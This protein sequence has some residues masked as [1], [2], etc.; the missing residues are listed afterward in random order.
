M[1]SA[2][3]SNGEV[4]R[5][6]HGLLSAG[7]VGDLSDGELLR[8]FTS[9]RGDGSALAFAELV[10]RHGAMV[11]RVCR[12][13]VRDEHDALDAFQATFL[14]L[15]RRAGL[16]RLGETVGPWLHGVALRTARGARRAAARR[17]EVERNVAGTRTAS[18]EPSL[19][20]HESAEALH[21]EIGRLPAGFRDAVVLCGLE[22]LSQEHA[23][24]RLG[25]PLGTLQSRLARGRARLRTRLERRG[26]GPA[27][28]AVGLSNETSK[29]LLP[30]RLCDT[31]VRTALAAL[32][33]TAI[34]QAAGS[35]T[36]PATVLALAKE[37]T[38]AM[39]VTQLKTTAAALGA[40][41][42]MLVCGAALA[43]GS[44]GPPDNSQKTPSPE[45]SSVNVVQFTANVDVRTKPAPLK[46]GDALLIEVLEALPNRPISGTRKV[47]SDGTI[48]L[49]FYGDIPVAGLNRDEIK[50]KVIEHLGRFLPAEK[51]GLEV[52]DASTNKTKKVPP[53]ESD[54][55]FV[56]DEMDGPKPSPKPT[57]SPSL[58]QDRFDA[59]EKRLDAL[60]ETIRK[61]RDKPAPEHS[62]AADPVEAQDRVSDPAVRITGKVRDSTTRT[63]VTIRQVPRL[64]SFNEIRPELAKA[65]QLMEVE[66][67]AAEFAMKQLIPTIEAM[68]DD[69]SEIGN[70]RKALLQKQSD[71]FNV[72]RLQ[73]NSSRESLINY[74]KERI[75]YNKRF[76]LKPGDLPAV[77]ES[78]PS[79]SATKA[80]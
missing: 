29:L 50:I 73:A 53:S 46:V 67:V 10:E 64:L 66:Q 40:L 30:Q 62:E 4:A 80:K 51:L 6:L 48:S 15:V 3:R 52:L 22:G 26:V 7:A 78:S 21:D 44:G 61:L 5:R 41:G 58:S 45:A 77:Q 68:K 38:G 31:A 28:M 34:G 16:L 25:C 11:L 57:P 37:V 60:T 55:V 43:T 54:R 49:G 71:A 35:G 32:S 70:L 27:A 69:Q 8:R 39:L 20:R 12:S 9:G 63:T 59:L 42:A 76:G 72:L 79:E 74:G 56:D 2:F 18:E 23:A 47:R 14:V 17:R 36:V 75:D 19:E 65:I 33:K 1:G 24:K 13:V